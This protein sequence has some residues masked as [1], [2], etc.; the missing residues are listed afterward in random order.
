MPALFRPMAT[1]RLACQIRN[2]AYQHAMLAVRPFFRFPIDGRSFDENHSFRPCMRHFDSRDDS[3]A[4]P[5][6]DSEVAENDVHKKRERQGSRPRSLV[7]I[8]L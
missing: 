3:L 2:R 4:D 8:S 5:I 7:G 6:S 1:L